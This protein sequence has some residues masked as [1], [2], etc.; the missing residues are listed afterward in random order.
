M[1]FCPKCGTRLRWCR[2]HKFS[3]TPVNR[4]LL[5]IQC[6]G[7]LSV[8]GKFDVHFARN[9]NEP[10]PVAWV[11]YRGHVVLEAYYSSELGP[12]VYLVV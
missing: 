3:S 8:C 1:N 7:F 12:R 5:F 2:C 9:I 6:I 11:D 10:Y 4:V